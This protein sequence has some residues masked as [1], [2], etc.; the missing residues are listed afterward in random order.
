MSPISEPSYAG[1]C[2]LASLVAFEKRLVHSLDA[3]RD[4]G[5]DTCR[6]S[7]VPLLEDRLGH[8][9][10]TVVKLASF[11]QPV[12]SSFPVKIDRHLVL[13]MLEVMYLYPLIPTHFEMF[14]FCV[15]GLSII[16]LLSP[17]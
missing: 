17:V 13:W 7:R 9:Q 14:H 2:L 12:D 8:V 16:T 3:R 5:S 1:L 15:S 10:L 11:P 6:P 4:L